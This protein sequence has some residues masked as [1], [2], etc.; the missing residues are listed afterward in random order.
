MCMYMCLREY[1]CAYEVTHRSRSKENLLWLSVL[2]FFHV[3]LKVLNLDHHAAYFTPD[4]PL[5]T[6]E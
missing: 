1:R 2:T 4:C 3:H 6:G 5:H